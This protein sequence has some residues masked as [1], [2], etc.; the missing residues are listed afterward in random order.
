M[1]PVV[2]VVNG[3]GALVQDCILQQVV[4]TCFA[5]VQELYNVA[6][7]SNVGQNSGF[8]P[9]YICCAFISPELEI[10]TVNLICCVPVQFKRILME[11]SIV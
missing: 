6:L 9:D 10:T 1:F 4:N 2:V 3:D 8:G 7:K 11:R 5:N